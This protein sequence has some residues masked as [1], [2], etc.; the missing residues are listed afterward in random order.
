MYVG[1]LITKIRQ[2]TGKTRYSV[3][4]SGNPTEGIP[5]TLVV[6][7]LNEAKDFIQAAIVSTGS[8]ICDE[9]LV[10]PLVANQADYI[11][12]DNVHLGNKVRNIQY[13][14]DSALRNYRDLPQLRDEER[15]SRTDSS[16]YGY[17][18]RGK[19][20]TLVPIPS[21]AG[22]SIRVEYPRQWDDFGLI[23]GQ[24]TS[25]SSTTIVLDN[26]TYLDSVQLG[27]LTGTSKVCIVDSEGEV[28][29]YDLAVVSYTSGTR[30]I[31][32]T[33]STLV[34]G[35][36]DFVVVGAFVSTHTDFLPSPLIQQYI[37]V[38]TQMRM[39]DTTTSVDAIRE[40]S[41]LKRVYEAIMEGYL[42]E[43]LDET[44]IPISDPYAMS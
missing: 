2:R 24:V 3:D 22:G 38:E 42:D 1:S 19:K 17:I 15:T 35:A 7:F 18:R 30:T 14:F 12:S 34:G 32:I 29:D 33:S 4:S 40:N 23:V 41:F 11:L 25:T 28:Q 31:T 16:P 6:D 44:D 5:Q 20:L 21:R 26:D 27:L 8:T 9:E 13:S 39:F 10:V 43:L 36:G 37:K